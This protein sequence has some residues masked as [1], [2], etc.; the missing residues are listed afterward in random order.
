MGSRKGP[1]RPADRPDHPDDML[2]RI[3][4]EL[5]CEE[6]QQDA[7]VAFGREFR[8]T[9]PRAPVPDFEDRTKRVVMK[10][11]KRGL[12]GQKLWLIGSA[13]VRQRF[14]RVR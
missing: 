7:Y 14:G 2:R 3:V 1:S 10:W 5:G 6:Q 8:R 12:S 9:L 13:L 4:A 11:W